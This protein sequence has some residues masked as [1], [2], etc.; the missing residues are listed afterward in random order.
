MSHENNHSSVNIEA[1]DFYEL[2][3]SQ[4][5]WLPF[6]LG[7]KS[8]SLLLMELWLFCE[9]YWKLAIYSIKICMNIISRM[10]IASY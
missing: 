1:T 7:I 9:V 3:N 6:E 8:V 10:V 2:P 4:D 5:K